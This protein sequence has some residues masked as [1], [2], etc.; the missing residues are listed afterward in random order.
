MSIVD[1]ILQAVFP[2]LAPRG[3]LTVITARG[4][5]LAFGDGTG[6]EIR[7]R[8]TD[9]RAEL[10]AVLDPYLY[11]GRL[12]MDG[13]YIV[14]RGT[15]YRFLELILRETGRHNKVLPAH[16]INQIR[17][18]VCRLSSRNNLLRSRR[19]VAHHYDLDA[20][21][22]RLFLD[23]DL[24]Y[25]CAYFERPEC[26]LEE[27]QLAKMRLVTAKLA[28]RSDSRVLDIG[29]GWGT[30]AFYLK[31]IA[32]AREVMGVT[33][34]A[35]QLSAARASAR[36]RS[37]NADVNFELRDYRA[38]EGTYDR[39]VSVGMFEHVG[40]SYY[41]TF[42]EKC[43]RLLKSDGVMLLHTIGHLDGPYDP[44]PWIEKYI[45]PGGHLP[46]LSQIVTAVERSGLII[47]DV[48]CLRVHYAK[49]LAEW[50]ERFMARRG[51]ALELYDERFCRMWE[52]YLAAS[53]ASFRY[54]NLGV[55]QV[56]CAR[57]ADTL[58]ITRDYISERIT[59]LRN[60]EMRCGLTEPLRGKVREAEL[61]PIIPIR[62][63]AGRW[64]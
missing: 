9:A 56:Q 59:D 22:Y 23:R 46:A 51:E 3:A 39:I 30:L 45:F 4:T 55:W 7:I 14:E 27:A 62:K 26:T 64:R 32:G 29:S 44:N 58:P 33:L 19:N 18:L 42:F 47:T 12:F 53:E 38:L 61:R 20:R 54:G 11:L 40:P 17:S 52:F 35:E 2:H 57:S 43:C 41:Q 60:A 24:Q 48:E 15:I 50:R 37:L 1:S 28:V 36:K 63:H 21:L 34:S 13:R 25:S 5:T 10:A 16:I 31:E 8:F 49:T 6:E